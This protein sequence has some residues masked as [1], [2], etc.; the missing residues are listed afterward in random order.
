MSGVNNVYS[1][2]SFYPEKI[3]QNQLNT[4]LNKLDDSGWNQAEEIQ[5]FELGEEDS[6]F[7]QKSEM[8]DEGLD[9]VKTKFLQILEFNKYLVKMVADLKQS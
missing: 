1:K 3:L 8:I 9:Q 5:G 7:E 6:E 2:E 4:G